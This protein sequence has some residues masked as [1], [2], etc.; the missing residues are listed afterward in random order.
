[1]KKVKLFEEFIDEA[2]TSWNKM[3]KGVKSGESGPWSI[4]VIKDNKVIDQK[5]NINVRDILPAEYEAMRKKYPNA[6]IHIEDSTGGVV[7]NESIATPLHA[8]DF[9]GM[10]A[11]A[12]NMSREEWIAHYGSPEIGSGID[13]S[14]KSIYTVFFEDT[15]GQDWDWEVEA[16]SPEEA[17]ELVQNGKAL[18]PYDQTLPR[19]ARNFSAKLYK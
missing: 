16:T 11:Q 12:A 7:W 2:T 17:I 3:M 15:K 1:M 6:K 9:L 5:I 19:G 8:Y 14:K 18:G 10:Q 4:V 13:E